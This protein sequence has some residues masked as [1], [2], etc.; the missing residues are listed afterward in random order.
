MKFRD[1]YD[2]EGRIVT[3][4][5]DIDGDGITVE[6]HESEEAA[7]RYLR[8]E[9]RNAPSDDEPGGETYNEGEIP[10]TRLYIARI[11]R[12]STL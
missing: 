1:L 10:N 12:R 7:E 6:F 3:L 11:V 2:G 8:E 5:D 4:V 9:Y